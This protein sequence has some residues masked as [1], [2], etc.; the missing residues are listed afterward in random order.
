MCPTPQQ[1]EVDTPIGC[2]VLRPSHALLESSN[3]LR[4]PLFLI[5]VF[6]HDS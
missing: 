1:A 2:D 3:N 4:L 6:G 5:G